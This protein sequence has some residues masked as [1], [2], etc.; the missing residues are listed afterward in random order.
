VIDVTKRGFV[1]LNRF[2]L[3]VVVTETV[4][5]ILECQFAKH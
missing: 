4:S 2:H 3:L 1:I 5:A